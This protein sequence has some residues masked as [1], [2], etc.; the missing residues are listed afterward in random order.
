MRFVLPLQGATSSKNASHH[1]EQKGKARQQLQPP[2]AK[3]T[4][5]APITPPYPAFTRAERVADGV[6]HVL[7]IGAALTGVT[8]LFGVLAQQWGWATLTATGIY[9]GALLLMLT[10]SGCY[11]ILAHTPARPIL[12][13]IDHAAIYIKIAGTMTPLGVL[14]GTG[15][16]YVVLAVVWALAL[17]GAITKLM[18]ARG[19]MSTGWL[20]YLVLGWAGL[21]L[22]IPLAG[23]VS[24]I[25]LVLMLLGGV[26]YSAG[27]IFYRSK[28]LRF[29]NAIWHAFVL[30]ASSA[31]FVG[32]SAAVTQAS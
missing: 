31:F 5:P 24:L 7:G 14:L 21:L 8:I 18:A 10:A 15:F 23:I 22:F 11:H 12:R 32:I 4:A 3:Q 19:R 17:L 16:A 2:R 25:S 26:L 30:L 27:I 13:R 28:G 6:V 20:P 9:A 1:A 29:A